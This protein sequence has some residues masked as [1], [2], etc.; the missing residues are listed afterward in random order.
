MEDRLSGSWAASMRTALAATMTHPAW[1]VMAL[2]A[3]LVRGGFVVVLLPLVSLPSVP[4]LS[5]A[6]AP[7]IEALILSRRSL[8]GVLIGTV[9]ISTI[10]GLLW[11]AGLAGSWLDLALLRD[12]AEAEELEGRVPLAMRSTWHA[13]GL[14][15]AAHLPTLLAL[16]YGT[17]RIVTVTYAELL[18]PGDQNVPLVARVVGRAPDAIALVIV[19]WL[20]GEA[21]GGL[22]ARRSGAG[23]PVIRSLGRAMRDLL[24]PRG[25][26]TFVVSNGVV[27]VA[28][29][30]LVTLV[31]RASEHLRAYIFDGANDIAIAAALLLLVSTWILCLALLGA[32]LAWRATAWTI[33]VGGSH[34]ARTATVAV[35]PEEAQTA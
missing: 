10:V 34:V 29:G 25:A 1:W 6:L 7:S 8:E 3:F 31:G 32:A 30:L 2:A 15:L 13:F 11:A 5:T 19:T 22:A 28:G 24:G 23:E 21:V 14:R 26:A 4:S 27:L 17:V 18:S 9:L 12:S 35:L 33:E 16:G 20:L